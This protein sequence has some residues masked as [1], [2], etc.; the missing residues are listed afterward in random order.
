MLVQYGPSLLHHAPTSLHISLSSL[1][2][3]AANSRY[4]ERQA[5]IHA[6]LLKRYNLLL[7]S[8]VQRYQ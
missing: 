3:A 5:A 2:S 4:Q 6:R 8:Q 7:G 1:P